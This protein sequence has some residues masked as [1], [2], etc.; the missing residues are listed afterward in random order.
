MPPMS[1]VNV[2][3]SSSSP[4]TDPPLNTT[5]D[6]IKTELTDPVR[7][8]V[9]LNDEGAGRLWVG[10]VDVLL[11]PDGS[12]QNYFGTSLSLVGAQLL[13]GNG[14]LTIEKRF[15]NR[16]GSPSQD[17]NG[18][19]VYTPGSPELAEVLIQYTVR[20]ANGATQTQIARLSTPPLL[21]TSISE[22]RLREPLGEQTRVTFDRS[23]APSL[24]APETVIFGLSGTANAGPSGA[25]YVVIGAKSFDPTNGTGMVEIPAGANQAAIV[26]LAVQDNIPEPVE[27]LR[28]EVLGA[29]SLT[30]G[31]I[32]AFDLEI[33][34]ALAPILAENFDSFQTGANSNPANGWEN[35]PESQFNW[36]ADANGTPTSN[37]GPSQDHTSGSGRYMYTEAS[38]Q[39]LSRRADLLSPTL[40]LA[41]ANGATL[42]FFYSMYGNTMGSLHVDVYNGASWTEDVFLVSGQQHYIGNAWTEANISLSGFL[43]NGVRVRFRGIVGS[44]FRS[45]MAID[46]VRIETSGSNAPTTP[47]ILAS[48]AGAS[49]NLGDAIYLAVAAVGS[50]APT[51]QWRQNGLNLPGA[52]SPAYQ[53]TSFNAGHAGS[54]EC[55]VSNSAG[56][57]LSAAAVL[58]IPSG[59]DYETWLEGFPEVSE[60]SSDP[61]GDFDLDGLSEIQE[62][63]HGL[64]PDVANAS[65]QPYVTQAINSSDGK[66][67]LQLTYRRRSGGAGTAGVNYTADGL[68]YTVESNPD[69]NPTTWQALGSGQSLPIGSP[70]ANGD[71][72]ETVTIRVLPAIEDNSRERFV[73]LKI[74]E[75]N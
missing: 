22:T 45:D 18:Y 50:P 39:N 61:L 58:V 1:I 75:A 19:L 28:L 68:V 26:V 67:Y 55:L 30:L 54:Y 72:T 35:G 63:A 33:S 42:S 9:L 8:N 65:G 40:N 34:D 29:S 23:S 31:R 46:D 41:G 73:R 10:E 5:E 38:S 52:T 71:G 51:Y 15:T 64:R 43:T 49:P 6:I 21:Q 44:N 56:S 11:G 12:D 27:Y 2:N 60:T 20:D 47:V 25:D 57:I 66:T 17:N 62:F 37:T 16:D 32:T 7:L 53:I 13:A 24:S 69:L 48:P 4:A 3:G 14:N 59:I 74:R 70:V 36:Q